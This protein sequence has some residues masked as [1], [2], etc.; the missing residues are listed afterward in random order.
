MRTIL[1]HFSKSML[2]YMAGK[3]Q[4]IGQRESSTS[5]RGGQIT[6]EGSRYL[7]QKWSI[8]EDPK[9]SNQGENNQSQG[10]WSEVALG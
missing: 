8:Q 4:L 10:A 7:F 6:H 9:E 1:A 2:V 3:E 5:G